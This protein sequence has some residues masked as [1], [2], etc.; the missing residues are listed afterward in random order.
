[1]TSGEARMPAPGLPRGVVVLVALAAAL[2]GTLAMRQVAWMI[3]P[4]ERSGRARGLAAPTDAR[5]DLRQ[6]DA[7]DVLPAM[8][9]V[10]IHDPSK[11]CV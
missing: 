9:R 8:T 5:P 2:V 3:R 11:V 1:M 6:P 7:A 4:E 10:D